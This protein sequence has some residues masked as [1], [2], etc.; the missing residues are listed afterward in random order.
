MVRYQSLTRKPELFRAP[1]GLGPGT[2]Y[3]LNPLLA[4]PDLEPYVLDSISGYNAWNQ[5]FLKQIVSKICYGQPRPCW[6]FVLAYD[7]KKV[8]NS[9]RIED[10]RTYW[11][12]IISNTPN[13]KGGKT[14]KA[15]TT[16]WRQANNHITQTFKIIGTIDARVACSFVFTRP[17]SN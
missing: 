10:C 2:M 5:L 14:S 7:Y 3:P 4:G 11:K 9:C 12:R 16:K 15:V 6:V 13:Q 17:F 8:A 1:L